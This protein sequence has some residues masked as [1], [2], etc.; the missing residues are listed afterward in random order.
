MTTQIEH[1][2]DSYHLFINVIAKQEHQEKVLSLL[3]TSIS[4]THKEEGCLEYK[5]FNENNIIFIKG[6]WKSKMSLDLHLLL[7][8]HL[9]LFEEQ[10]P[11]LCEK[12]DIQVV[13]EVEPPIT[14]LSLSS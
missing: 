14:S 12:I 3:Y 9:A 10:L 2:K 5:L 7:Q 11:G 1:I 6:A 8:F 4:P 13:H